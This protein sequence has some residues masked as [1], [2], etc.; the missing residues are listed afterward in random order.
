MLNLERCLPRLLAAALLVVVGCDAVEPEGEQLVVEAFVEAGRPLG[1]VT[2]RRTTPLDAPGAGNPAEGATVTLTLGEE[3]IPY[4]ADSAGRYVPA[5]DDTLIVPERA[6]LTLE[7]AWQG[8]RATARSR[9]PPEIAIARVQVD[10]PERPV[11]AV[12]LDSLRLDSLGI[13]AEEGFVYPIEVSVWWETDFAETGADSLYWIRARLRPVAP[14]SSEVLDFFLRPE[15]IFRERARPR[16]AD[17]RRRWRG[18]YA[19]PVERRADPLPAHR[20]GVALVRGGE[21]YARF[22]ATAG[23]PDRREPVSNVEGA[24]GI[25]AGIALDSLSV[26]VE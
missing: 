6:V 8:Q 3:R 16:L 22:A 15:E 18:V 11:E 21:D 5:V 1:A 13:G 26:R 12:L 4:R 19:V 14:F 20:L 24:L 2:L 10:V 25:A 23:D 17:R 9:V 7:A